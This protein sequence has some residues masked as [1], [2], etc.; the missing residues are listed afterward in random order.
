[1]ISGCKQV[2][3]CKQTRS[4]RTTNKKFFPSQPSTVNRQQQKLRSQSPH[5]EIY[6]TGNI[7]TCHLACVQN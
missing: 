2:Y 5:C 3:L 6:I 1:M 4:S 7:R